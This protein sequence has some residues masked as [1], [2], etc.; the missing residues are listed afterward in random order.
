MA[1]TLTMACVCTWKDTHDILQPHF[2]S[3]FKMEQNCI[4]S[5]IKI[6]PTNRSAASQQA[7][8]QFVID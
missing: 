3:H 1:L 4:S 6:M 8:F 7:A 2:T 5:V